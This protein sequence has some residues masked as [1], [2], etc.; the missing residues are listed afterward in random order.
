M[1]PRIRLGGLM[2]AG[3]ADGVSGTTSWLDITS[4]VMRRWLV[5]EATHPEESTQQHTERGG[6][7]GER[8]GEGLIQREPAA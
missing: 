7:R 2:A 6:G 1:F 3:S 5:T 4:Q 8:D